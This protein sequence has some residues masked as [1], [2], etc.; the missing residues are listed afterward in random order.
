MMSSFLDSIAFAPFG[1]DLDSGEYD[2]Y[3]NVPTNGRSPSLQPE[4][5]G[6]G[7]FLPP[8]LD[9]SFHSVATALFYDPRLMEHK[10]LFCNPNDA[11]EYPEVPERVRRAYKELE[12]RGLAARC[13]RIPGRPATDAEL[14]LVHSTAH[15]ESIRAT[16]DMSLEQLKDVSRTEYNDVYFAPST[17]EISALSCGGAI[18]TAE[19]VWSGIFKNGIAIIRP[20]GHHAES[21]VAM[22]FCI[23]NNVAVAAKYLQ[24][25][26]NVKRIMILDWDVHHGN[27]TQRIFYEDPTV[28]YVS[29]H[30]FDDGKFFP[31]LMIAG[32]D[33]TGAT[34]ADGRNVNIPWAGPGKNDAD[35]LHAFHSVIMPIAHEFAPDIVLVSAGF[36][37]ACGDPLG[38]CN[39]S[40]AGYA[41]MTHQLMSLA[42]GKIVVC[43]EGG[44]H[45]NAVANSIAAV[46]GTLLGD[47]PAPLDT[48]L[49]ISADCANVVHKVREVQSPFWK[50]LLPC[51]AAKTKPPAIPN[52]T[53]PLTEI[54]AG[55]RRHHLAHNLGLEYHAITDPHIVDLQAQI[56]TSFEESRGYISSQTNNIILENTHIHTASL[57]Y[58]ESLVSHA[59]IDIEIGGSALLKHE[60]NWLAN[61]V[62]KYA[63]D[64]LGRHCNA[65]RV[66][67]IGSDIGASA[68]ANLLSVRPNLRHR[69]LGAAMLVSSGPVP[70]VHRTCAEWYSSIS[71]V[72]M[73]SNMPL[74]RVISSELETG[75]CISAGP[76]PTHVAAS[77]LMD[78][79][80]GRVF[81]FFAKRMEKE[82]LKQ[83]DRR[84]RKRLSQERLP[85]VEEPDEP[86]TPPQQQH[87]SLQERLHRRVEIVLPNKRRRHAPPSP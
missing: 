66:F 35:Y 61:E 57:R 34:G 5:D 25:Q 43:L 72:Y 54:L 31:K 41:Q 26:H 87:L 58:L 53:V 49:R 76:A 86:P 77:A 75:R 21:D 65:R 50:C 17:A 24:T 42:N 74:G 9:P 1:D 68:M 60:R 8:S 32:M 52:T 80:H 51:Y 79:M 36:D 6:D 63:W 18:V 20:P 70:S 2:Q 73:F 44:Y 37:A 39:V 7:I 47:A 56:H 48:K 71:R 27:G 3:D 33:Y 64:T 81:T 14:Q 46:T 38:E 59:V 40:P 15:M 55:Y 10:N 78:D 67:L 84:R 85:E 82:Y 28:L 13:Y 29:I 4:S 45:L 22:G 30:R 11:D 19:A 83:L 62:T 16:A 12:K 23:Y 69:T